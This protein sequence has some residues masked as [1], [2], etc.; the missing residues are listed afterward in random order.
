MISILYFQITR[1]V[2]TNK[3]RLSGHIVYKRYTSSPA[4]HFHCTWLYWRALLKTA[5][6]VPNSPTPRVSS[7]ILLLLL[8]TPSVS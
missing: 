7:I 5:V 2:D 1:H 4:K 3:K 8:I 6:R